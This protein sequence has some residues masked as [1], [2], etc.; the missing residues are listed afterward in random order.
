M[1]IENN[2]AATEKGR[3]RSLPFRSFVYRIAPPEPYFIAATRA[4]RRDLYREAV[5]SC[6]VPF[7]IALS[8][9]E[10]VFR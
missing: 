1:G 5:F 6:S 7:W 4:L 10:T 2:R 3:L 9:A 8:R